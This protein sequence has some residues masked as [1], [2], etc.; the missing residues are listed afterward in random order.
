MPIAQSPGDEAFDD[1]DETDEPA[2]WTAVEAR[3][4]DA[5][6][7]LLVRVE[8]TGESS[9][10]AWSR[11]PIAAVVAARRGP[12]LTP[13]IADVDWLIIVAPV[14]DVPIIVVGLIVELMATASS[15]WAATRA[16]DA[17]K[18]PPIVNSSLRPL[19]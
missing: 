14:D 12:R 9:G 4:A 7:E 1:D 11:A 18:P 2:G 3:S 8:V 6:D 5:V 15:S 10:V 13:P 17:R 16:D 19:L